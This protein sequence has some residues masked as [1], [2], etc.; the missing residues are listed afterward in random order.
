[1]KNN[2]VK[3]TNQ[4]LNVFFRVL[5]WTGN[6][7]NHDHSSDIHIT[8]AGQIVEY[9]SEYLARIQATLQAALS[10][11]CESGLWTYYAVC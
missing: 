4:S 3:E 7:D 9:S 11:N 5:A 10:G 1:M 6:D 8:R 2:K